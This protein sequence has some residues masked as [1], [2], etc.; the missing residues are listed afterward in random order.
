MRFLLDKLS[1]ASLIDAVRAT[2]ATGRVGRGFRIFP[3]NDLVK[4]R[5][6]L[7][8]AAAGQTQV[9]VT[10]SIFS[11]DGDAADLT[12]LAQLKRE[13]PFLLLLDEAHGSGVYGMN[14]SG[15]AIER[16]MS[17]LPNVVVVTFSKALGGVG[18]AVCASEAFCELLV[19]SARPFIY[20]TAPPPSVAAAIEA[21]IGVL[22]D[23]PA[24]SNVCEAWRFMSAASWPRPVCACLT[25]THRSC[26]SCWDPSRERFKR[27]IGCW[28]TACSPCR[29]ARPRSRAVPAGSASH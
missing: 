10:E 17:A 11:M 7:S 21:A 14:G 1:H 2:A 27:H 29:S 26:P 6:L 18:G 24:V 19:N 28:R 20:S 13:H 9:V 25:G 12:G 8:E 15:L 3:H 23:E 5:R 22:Y 16:G 4:L